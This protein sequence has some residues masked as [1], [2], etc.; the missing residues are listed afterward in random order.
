MY[1]G[2]C[3]L[4]CGERA[5][6]GP[7]L[8]EA[9]AS[10]SGGGWRLGAVR[11]CGAPAG[12]SGQP[13]DSTPAVQ[14]ARQLGRA[15]E[16]RRCAPS[17]RLLLATRSTACPDA[18]VRANGPQGERRVLMKAR[19]EPWDRRSAAQA[20][21]RLDLAPRAFVN[22][23]PRACATGV[24]LARSSS[25]PRGPAAPAPRLTPPTTLHTT[26]TAL[27]PVPSAAASAQVGHPEQAHAGR[28]EAATGGPAGTC[29]D[30]SQP[31]TAREQHGRASRPPF[32]PPSPAA[33]EGPL[34]LR[35]VPLLLPTSPCI[36][37]SPPLPQAL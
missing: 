29:P 25:Q 16:R 30:A 37:A 24:G 22:P 31:S 14:R 15:L 4:D 17:R 6:A 3:F 12:V 5:A 32:S 36:S 26:L 35:A 10:G 33:A 19:I 34:P 11:V 20:R 23:S 2:C 9:A 7:V 18:S 21:H 1:L 13:P 28:P 8:A 27:S